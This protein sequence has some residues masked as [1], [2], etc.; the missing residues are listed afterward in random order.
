MEAVREGRMM[1][2]GIDGRQPKM[3]RNRGTSWGSNGDSY[4]ESPTAVPCGGSFPMALPSPICDAGPSSSPSWSP[5]VNVS[6]CH[7]P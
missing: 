1:L 2:V 3:A 4:P 7:T 5:E 6:R